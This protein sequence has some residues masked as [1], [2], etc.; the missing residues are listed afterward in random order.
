[1]VTE[2]TQTFLLRLAFPTLEA[3][4]ARLRAMKEESDSC[5]AWKALMQQRSP[6]DEGQ[7]DI[8]G[9]GTQTLHP[10]P[11]GVGLLPSAGARASAS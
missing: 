10:A 8:Q 4:G 6:A 1:M 5:F 11:L 2:Q 7:G 3:F 9:H